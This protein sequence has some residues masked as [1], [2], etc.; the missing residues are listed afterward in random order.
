MPTASFDKSHAYFS[1]SWTQGGGTYFRC[2][3]ADSTAEL[4]ATG[5]ALTIGCYITGANVSEVSVDGGAFVDIVP[6]GYNGYSTATIFSGLPNLAHTVKIR[7]KAAAQFYL[8]PGPSNV[9]TDPIFTVTSTGVPDCSPPAGF[10]SATNY[11][12]GTATNGPM[13]QIG[14]LNHVRLE[15]GFATTNDASQGYDP[16]PK[17]LNIGLGS[18]GSASNVRYGA[19]IRLKATTPRLDVWIKN[20]GQAYGLIVDGVVPV[21]RVITPNTGRWGWVPLRTDL[22]GSAEHTYGICLSSAIGSDVS[23]GSGEVWAIRCPG[24]TMNTASQPALRDTAL[25]YGDSITIGD[26]AL[27]AAVNGFADEADALQ[28]WVLWT[29]ERLDM[30]FINAGIGGSTLRDCTPDDLSA[31]SAPNRD[32]VTKY[33]GQARVA[34]DVGGASP[35]PTKIV[36]LYGRNDVGQVYNDAGRPIETEAQFQAAAQSMAAAINAAQPAADVYY[37]GI[38]PATLANY[39][40]GYTDADRQA[41]NTGL[42]AALTAVG[43]AKN[44]YGT[45]DLVGLN[46]PPG[47]NTGTDFG[48]TML[49]GLH[50]NRLGRDP[51]RNRAYN[52]ITGTPTIGVVPIAAVAPNPVPAYP[53]KAYT[54]RLSGFGTAWVASHNITASAGMIGT[55]TVDRDGY[56]RV[57][58]TAPAS[59]QS[60]T[61]TD[62]GSG[63]TGTLPVVVPA[64]TLSQAVANPGDAVTLTLTAPF[65][66]WLSTGQTTL[67]TSPGLDLTGATV[68]GLGTASVSF[69]VPS[70]PGG[71]VVI[72]D[73]STGQTATLNITGHPSRKGRKPSRSR[74]IMRSR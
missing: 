49:D 58:Y 59:P 25:F 46:G 64:L 43:N 32:I 38:L 13:G 10:S 70:T 67:F 7:G 5:T 3:G 12:L 35:T 61:I 27:K 50:P 41:F 57:P 26:M 62:V 45:T 8:T 47:D 63:A 6:L 2:D 11:L 28:G 17:N 21:D 56:V 31:M 33:S 71:S 73:T 65:T 53:S 4:V 19:Q 48:P 69:T 37:L 24:G 51:L 22:D 15:S 1:G 60:V 36:V 34:H 18:D 16:I 42:Q 14:A 39:R 68:S 30:Q 29:A 66:Y 72:T 40:G 44:H 74:S 52:L 55:P 20:D 9:A 54:L 23:A